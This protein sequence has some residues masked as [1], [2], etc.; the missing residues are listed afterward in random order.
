MSLAGHGRARR[1]AAGRGAAGHGEARLGWARH[2][3]ARRG[4]ARLGAAG[5]G[6]ARQGKGCTEGVGL[7]VTSPEHL[8]NGEHMKD[9]TIRISGKTPLLL[10][11]FTDRGADGGHIGRPIE[12]CQ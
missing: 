2:G 6:E 7:A 8:T 3:E 11:R 5:P 9:I 4:S 12:H 10:H 1:G